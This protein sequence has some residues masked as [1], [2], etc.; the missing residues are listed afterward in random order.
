MYSRFSVGIH[1]EKTRINAQI[2]S[3]FMDAGITV[4]SGY[5]KLYAHTKTGKE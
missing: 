3:S 5:A 4:V 2:V 1:L